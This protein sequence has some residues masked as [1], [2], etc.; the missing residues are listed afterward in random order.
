LARLSLRE[1]VQDFQELVHEGLTLE[2]E[3]EML[4]VIFVEIVRPRGVSPELH[5]RD[6]WFFSHTVIGL[7]YGKKASVADSGE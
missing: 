4:E 2:A 6:V 5:S 3:K 1:T 7:R